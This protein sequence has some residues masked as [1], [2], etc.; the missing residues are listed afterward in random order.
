MKTICPV[1]L[2]LLTLCCLLFA[3][4][5]NGGSIISTIAGTGLK[6]YIG[7]NI[8]GVVSE[9]QPTDLAYDGIRNL[10]YILTNYNRLQVLNV[11]SGIVT[12]VAGTGVQVY[13]ADAGNL[14]VRVVDTTT[15]IITTFA[16][17]GQLSGD[18]DG[19]DATLG[20]ML[21]LSK[22]AVDT[23]NNLVYISDTTDNRVR[24]V[25]RTSGIITT[26]AGNQYPQFTSD[27]V[28]ATKTTLWQ[29]NGIA[30]D[31]TRNLVYIGDSSNHRVRVVN[32]LTGIINTFAGSGQAGYNGE[33]AAKNFKINRPTA[34]AVDNVN[35][36]VYIAE[37]LNYRVRAVNV[38][39]NAMS[40]VVGTGLLTYNGDNIP[41]NTAQ[42][43]HPGSIA[44]D[45]GNN[46]IY[47][48]D[49][50]NNRV[51]VINRTSGI[52]NTFAGTG[53]SGYSG[54][55]G[56]ATRAQITRPYGLAVDSSNNLVYIS[57]SDNFRV[58]VVNTLTGNISTFAGTGVA[59]ST[60]DGGN[61]TSAKLGYPYGL[62]VDSANNLVYIADSTNHRIR[63]V[64]R[65]TGAIN[66]FAGTGT[67]GYS[68]DGGNATSANL[69]GPLGVA[70]DVPR[71]L[72]YVADSDNNVIR[73]V[74]RSSGAISLVAG[75]TYAGNFGDTRPALNAPVS[76]PYGIS[77]D[78]FNNLIFIA[79]YDNH[80][81]RVID[82]SNGNIYKFAGGSNGAQ[83]FGGDGGPAA[84]DA[85]LLFYPTSVAQDNA[86]NVVYVADTYNDRIRAVT[87]NYTT[88]VTSTPTPT[89]TPTPT[90]TSTTVPDSTSTASTLTPMFTSTA[91]PDS[92]STAAP[93]STRVPTSTPVPTSF[94]PPRAPSIKIDQGSKITTSVGSTINLKAT[95]TDVPSGANTTWACT[96][97]D[98]C[99]F[100]FVTNSLTQ[101]VS[102]KIAGTFIVRVTLKSTTMN[103]YAEI[104]LIVVD[105]AVPVFI[106]TGVKSGSISVSSGLSLTA[107]PVSSSYE[108]SR[109]TYSWTVLQSDGTSTSLPSSVAID[110]ATLY[111]PANTLVAGIYGIN[112][113]VKISTSNNPGS[114]AISVSYVNNRI[115]AGSLSLSAST[116]APLSS[117]VAT[118][119]GFSDSDPIIGDTSSS[120]TYEYS[121]VYNGPPKILNPASSNTSVTISI[122]YIAGSGSITF[123]V[124]VRNGLGYS[125]SNSTTFNVGAIVIPGIGSA[126]NNTNSTAVT[127]YFAD[128]INNAPLTSAPTPAIINLISAAV[129]L[130]NEARRNVAAQ[131]GVS[132]SSSTRACPN[133]CFNRGS[134]SSGKCTCNSGFTGSDCGFTAAELQ[135]QQTFITSALMLVSNAFKFIPAN[136]TQG[137]AAAIA[138]DSSVGS[139]IT[140]IGAI[141]SNPD[142][143]T[144]D[145]RSDAMD[146]IQS[147]LSISKG[148]LSLDTSSIILDVVNSL[149]TTSTFS[150]SSRSVAQSVSLAKK[151]YNSACNVMDGIAYG[152]SPGDAPAVIG[153][154]IKVLV[155]KGYSFNVG[156]DGT[157]IGNSTNVAQLIVPTN[158]GGLGSSSSALDFKAMSLPNNIYTSSKVVA[159]NL[160]VIH[161]GENCDAAFSLKSLTSD[162]K[163]TIPGKFN[164][165]NNYECQFW[166]P[167]IN[168]YSNYGCKTLQVMVDRIS[169]SCNHTTDY[170]AVQVDRTSSATPASNGGL[171][172]GQIA[173]IV[174]GSIAG[175][176]IIIVLLVVL[177]N[178]P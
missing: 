47:V 65:L 4:I 102:S 51:R 119:V 113:V 121:Y 67:G 82:R 133:D 22:L 61:A 7:E 91:V 3:A 26:F 28:Q 154:T 1:L 152:M 169:C 16:L 32:R 35:G 93:T 36:F 62:S 145:A 40:T 148:L 9:V 177:K 92:T 55:G 162:V 136:V 158:A 42:L 157:T 69:K 71:N 94:I 130:I 50:D 173:G 46:L 58:R 43:N 84:A 176:V 45:A 138:L 124:V 137:S 30:I 60:G 155:A 103:V 122:P 163:F 141:V 85:A 74:D 156:S 132:G 165:S 109:A 140:N 59:G 129:T 174:I 101:T 160:F 147:M 149:T 37:Y 88:I 14:R 44:V 53:T 49:I 52:I 123:V 164:T 167:L 117:I 131:Q 18:G 11:S 172:G 21:S 110:K 127:S 112:C 72:V 75:T 13:I 95:V 27:G 64:D 23:D 108:P 83:G 81:I 98:N 135:A 54:D 105:G 33:G 34:V 96:T 5:D 20:S 178:N 73:V 118:S 126:A 41:A 70:V 151:A 15:K 134:C 168:D 57:D 111:I 107:V 159:S 78:S 12:T 170:V 171:T 175:A 100:N 146:N 89:P 31:N 97:P 120:L 87:T 114:N 161:L 17:N 166:N 2:L 116:G 38:T 79:Q 24:V 68:G 25:N 63:V 6:G 76:K 104:T 86:N 115:V 29:P 56:A 8:Q 125:A 128:Q 48:A 80:R 10:C 106:I 144:T 90:S 142:T 19:G 66:T 150:G 153:S 139:T 143:V 77:V 99:P 39:S